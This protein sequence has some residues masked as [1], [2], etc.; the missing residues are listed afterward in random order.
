MSNDYLIH[1]YLD[2]G[3]DASGEEAM[4]LALAG[5]PLLRQEFSRQLRLNQVIEEEARKI[6]PPAVLASSIFGQLGYAIPASLATTA[7]AVPFLHKIFPILG[8]IAAMV[9]LSLLAVPYSDIEDD[10]QSQENQRLLFVSGLSGQSVDNVNQFEDTGSGLLTRYE[11][12]VEVADSADIV[13]RESLISDNSNNTPGESNTQDF[14]S[15]NSISR[16]N[17]SLSTGDSRNNVQDDFSE[18]VSQISQENGGNN[19]SI[20]NLNPEDI[21]GSIELG[22][23]YDNPG[24]I[25][26]L[27]RSVKE[28]LNE[29]MASEEE[30]GS[31][32]QEHNIDERINNSTDLFVED[33]V[34]PGAAAV[35]YPL[36]S[37]GDQF[38]TVHYIETNSDPDI[39]ISN[40]IPS[41]GVNYGFHL[42]EYFALV[43]D[44]GMED[45][46][47][48]FGFIQNGREVVRN[49]NP[50]VYY[51][52]AGL[53]VNT[54]YLFD[55]WM[56]YAQ[57]TGGGSNFGPLARGKLGMMVRT[58]EALSFS[59]GY[60]YSVLLYTVSSDTYSTTNSG[61]SI[62]LVYHF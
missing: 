55:T 47:Q 44:G 25:E 42:G 38:L 46:G 40:S 16:D 9:F 28:R 20:F 50:T 36:P 5:D 57:I 29:I 12:S 60:E 48:S 24:F 23:S 53:R 59:A 18:D 56:P 1:Q 3:L 11:N 51:Y 6:T 54:P 33:N 32:Q 39:S 27:A 62:G 45:Y 34:I 26:M 35:I 10:S 14:V 58:N 31:I 4:F 15:N 17:G 13:L 49:Q 43:F 7:T 8:S 41:L 2:T 22:D 30:S 21:L 37:F 52:T 61:Y 19:L